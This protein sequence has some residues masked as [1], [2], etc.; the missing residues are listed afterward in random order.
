MAMLSMLDTQ[1]VAS[2]VGEVLAV[3]WLEV[4]ILSCAAMVFIAV[5]GVRIGSKYQRELKAKRTQEFDRS[6]TAPIGSAKRKVPEA[7]LAL[8]PIL[9]ALHN[10][11]LE[12]ALVLLEQL[13][14]DKLH[15]ALE[16]TAPR[17]LLLA[18]S[19]ADL[20]NAAAL[21]SDFI[22]SIDP[23]MLEL[24]VLEAQKRKNS[25]LCAQLDQL[26]GLLSIKKSQLTM[27]TRAK[28]YS[29]NVEEHANLAGAAAL[30]PLA[31]QASSHV[32]TDDADVT[33][34]SSAALKKMQASCQAKDLQGAIAIF[35]SLPHVNGR[36][37]A[38]LLNSMV[39][40]C[41]ECGEWQMAKSYLLK[42]HAEGN[43]SSA[44]FV[45]STTALVKGLHALGDNNAVEQLLQEFAEQGIQVSRPSYHTLL[46]S[47]AVASD[48]AA[49][50][51]LVSNMRRAGFAPDSV[52]CSILLKVV[53]S[54]VHTA[55]L[56]KIMK[57]VGAME[58]EVD[59]VLL[60][61][62]TE[63]SLCTG[64]VD[65][66]QEITAR[67]TNGMTLKT[68][69]YGS[70]IKTYGQAGMVES[71]W[72]IWCQM[73]TKNVQPTAITVGCMVEALVFNKETDWA[74]KLVQEILEDESQRHLVNSVTYSTLFKGFCTQPEK[75]MA[76][77]KDMAA[78]QIK[79][80]TITY[81]TILNHFAQCRSMSRVPQILEDM[82]ASIPRADPD[83]VTYSTIIRGFCLSGNLDR[84]LG[85]LAEMQAV[86]KFLP[87]E[88][89]YNIML[90]GCA[91]EQRLAD[92]LR[93][94]DDM[95]KTGVAPNNCT[96][97][98][99]V[100]LLG[101][102]RMLSKAFA[103]VDELTSE[104]GIRPNIQVYTCMIQGC[105]H[106]RQPAKALSVFEQLLADGLRPDEK[107]NVA[108]VRGHLQN[109]LIEKA[110]QFVRCAYQDEA[111]GVDSQC[112]GEVLTKL[113]V[114][115][116]AAVALQKEVEAGRKRQPQGASAMTRFSRKENNGVSRRMDTRRTFVKER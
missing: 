41:I 104:F 59:D 5:P 89:L 33:K 79:C 97:S 26:A 16:R 95:K 31:K 15:V 18:A 72:G 78:R 88:K 66:I 102:C 99:L 113:G 19:S 112:L 81:N 35:E 82:K 4:M 51:R 3:V 116:E 29:G 100:K 71:A 46:N 14:G 7:D 17:F 87:D 27:S 42:V 49:V 73:K 25:W 55:D 39:Q 92:A 94:V 32:K 50:W 70:L 34:E 85:L 56:L 37:G 64:Q 13:P 2:F 86:G 84:A 44:S 68:P 90:D 110:A 93:L 10:G 91:R 76:V 98:T 69:L 57:L 101:R 21:I 45:A 106:N 9:T 83:I 38:Q 60:C 80:C 48:R 54:Q 96:L 115:S 40:V 30:H 77:Y 114:G 43:N 1:T 61:S 36:I 105:F 24:A 109:G 23:R 111:A 74:W 20:G 103:I 67:R 11:S 62:I 12:E 8:S 28:S 6:G 47:Y 58:T 108:M 63:A 22:G 53:T 65:F 75:I 52:T 107:A